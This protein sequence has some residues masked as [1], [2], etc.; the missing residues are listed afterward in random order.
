MVALV[1]MLGLG[2]GAITAWLVA[3]ARFVARTAVLEAELSHERE[4][5]AETA[6]VLQQARAELADHFKALSYDALKAN[7]ESFVDLL[8][9]QLEQL[10]LRASGELEA[11]QK[12]VE[13][14]VGPIKESLQ[15][16]DTQVRTIEEAR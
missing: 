14:L 12:A 10:Q 2:V 11:R 15:R 5:G 7:N 1:L 3:R 9:P 13:Q 4:R 8:K 6:A 16:V